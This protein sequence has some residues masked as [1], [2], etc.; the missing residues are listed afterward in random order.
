MRVWLAISTAGTM[1]PSK[2]CWQCE[3]E[4]GLLDSGRSVVPGKQI[5]DSFDGVCIESWKGTCDE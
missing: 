1:N 4:Y 3:H 5:S 2:T